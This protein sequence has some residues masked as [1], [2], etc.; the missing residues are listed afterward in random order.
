MK[1]IYEEIALEVLKFSLEE[2]RMDIVSMS[3]NAKDDVEDD[4][5]SGFQ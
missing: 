2:I 4:I 1:K 3:E 5:F